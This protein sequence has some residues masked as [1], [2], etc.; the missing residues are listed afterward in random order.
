MTWRRGTKAG[1][2]LGE[3]GHYGESHR[4]AWGLLFHHMLASLLGN[5]EVRVSPGEG[6]TDSTEGGKTLCSVGS[7]GREA[8]ATGLAICTPIA[9]GP[10]LSQIGPT[11]SAEAGLTSLKPSLTSRSAGLAFQ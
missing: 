4:P 5:E 8:L 1:V 9:L 6:Q 3:C 2:W 10:R 11:G 7:G